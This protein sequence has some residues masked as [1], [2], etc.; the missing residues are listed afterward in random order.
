LCFGEMGGHVD[1]DG[2]G[3]SKDGRTLPSE[4]RWGSDQ[5]HRLLVRTVEENLKY[6]R[7]RCGTERKKLEGSA[8]LIRGS[9]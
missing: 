3:R 2:D 7:L 1:D 4:A 8:Y 6:F 9:N 5:S